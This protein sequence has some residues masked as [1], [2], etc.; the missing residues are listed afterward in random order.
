[1][2]CPKCKEA[3]ME[4]NIT[5]DMVVTACPACGHSCCY[6]SEAEEERI[7]NRVFNSMFREKN[8][9]RKTVRS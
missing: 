8:D 1:M 2:I 5:T 3:A 7:F 4:S 9:E 6:I